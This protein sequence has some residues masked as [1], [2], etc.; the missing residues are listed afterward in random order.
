ME[1]WQSPLWELILHKYKSHIIRVPPNVFFYATALLSCPRSPGQDD[2]LLGRHGGGVEIKQRDEWD[3]FQFVVHHLSLLHCVVFCPEQLAACRYDFIAVDL[4]P[5][6]IP[7]KPQPPVPG[8]NYFV[9]TI[10][11]KLNVLFVVANVIWDPVQRDNKISPH[12][13]SRPGWSGEESNDS[14]YGPPICIGVILWRV[15]FYCVIYV[16][17]SHIFLAHHH[18]VHSGHGQWDNIQGII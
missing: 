6:R 16:Q 2:V 1:F 10:N 13:S 9:S 4:A 17:Y 8:R 12:R 14:I 11:I 3:S 15:A 7:N 5:I 18:S